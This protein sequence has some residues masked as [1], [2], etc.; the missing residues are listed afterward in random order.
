M[1]QQKLWV[2]IK[3]QIGYELSLIEELQYAPYF[4]TIYD[5]VQFARTKN[6][7]CQGR[8]SAGN[9]SVCYVLG[10]TSVNPSEIDL[11]FERFISSER[12]EPPDIDVDFEH[13]RREEVIQYIYEKYGRNCCGITATHVTYRYKSAFQEIGKVMGLSKDV[14]AVLSATSRWGGSSIKNYIREAGLNPED[15]T[16]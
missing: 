10:I 15:P 8:G 3:K 11:L 4:L 2:N 5:I 1:K 6:I 16:L 9:S 12:N 7:L 13:E 14:L